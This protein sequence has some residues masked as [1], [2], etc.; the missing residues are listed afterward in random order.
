MNKNQVILAFIK[1]R[2]VIIYEF[3]AKKQKLF[4]QSNKN[5]IN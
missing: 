1:P 2:F 5:F 3:G 4:S